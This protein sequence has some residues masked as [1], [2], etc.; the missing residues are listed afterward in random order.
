MVLRLG[1]LVCAVVGA[2]SCQDPE[3]VAIACQ[4]TGISFV[5]IKYTRVD[6]LD[7][8]FVVDNSISMADKQSE[9]ARRIPEMIAAVTGPDPATGKPSPVHDVH[10]GVISS[11]LGSHGTSACAV[12]VTNKHVNDRGHLLPRAGEGGGTGWTLD[13]TGAPTSA[14][15][16]TP[17]TATALSWVYDSA[18]PE[19]AA[20]RFK[21]PAGVPALQLATSCVVQSVKDDGCGYEETWEAAYHFLVDPAPYAKA[22]VRCTFGIA[23][24]ACGNNKIAVEGLDEEL[25]A[26]R[27]A[28]LRPDS[29][30]AVVILSDENDASLKPAGLNWL[31]WG[32]GAGKL[33]RG[34]GACADVP[35]DFEPDTPADYSRLHNELRCFSCFEDASDPYVFSGK[36]AP[37]R[38]ASAP[39]HACRKWSAPPTSGSSKSCDARMRRC[40]RNS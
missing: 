31:P 40:V 17:V 3:V 36:L 25:L 13:G 26:Q 24:D 12:E 23:G 39:A 5:K 32:Y 20:A 2:M 21:G 35:D 28:F 34:W 10:V 7:L 8:L 14:V 15:C 30:L 33:L 27:K 9:L 29:L 22:E 38:A 11:S 6:K 16:P 19:A 1:V 18:N 37:A 4:S